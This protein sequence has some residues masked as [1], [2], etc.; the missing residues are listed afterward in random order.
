MIGGRPVAI[1]VAESL[2][3]RQFDGPEP[4]LTRHGAFGVS[5]SQSAIKLAVIGPMLGIVAKRRLTSQARCH[6][7]I[8]ASSRSISSSNRLS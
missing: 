2:L 6:S 4:G 3:F 5:Q 8:P 1:Q 7:S